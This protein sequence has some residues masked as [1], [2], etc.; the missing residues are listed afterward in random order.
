MCRVPLRRVSS[1]MPLR[2][3]LLIGLGL[4]LGLGQGLGI[5]CARPL[6]WWFP[7]G[8]DAAV[9]PPDASLCAVAP[10]FECTRREGGPCSRFI[11]VSPD[12]TPA[13][14]WHCPEGSEVLTETVQ[15]VDSC[16]PLYGEAS[17][18]VWLA[19]A[20]TPVER[21]DGRCM[22]ILSE[23]V[24]ETDERLS[25]PAVILPTSPAPG[26]C[27][28]GAEVLGGEEP[29]SV[30]DE[31]DLGDDDIASLG[32]GFRFGGRTWIY[33]RHWVW[34]ASQVFG[35]RLL[36]TRLAWYHD[37]SESVRFLDG[38]LWDAEVAFG[39]AAVVADGVPHVFGCH[40][41][42]VFLSTE[43]HVARLV[44]ADIG[45]PAAYEHYAGGDQWSDDIA[46]EVPIFE[47]GPHR[48]AVRYHPGV[49]RYVLLF[50]HGFGTQI[51]IRTAPEP[52]GPWTAPSVLADCDLPADDPD[53]FCAT[54]AMHLELMSDWHPDDLAVTYDIGTL[55]PDAEARRLADPAAYWPRLVRLPM[56]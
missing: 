5:G 29:F 10:G 3:V 36:G 23:G 45:D 54:P 14:A 38:F 12:C 26:N 18:F 2:G 55:A 9:A 4:G 56:H 30:A 11:T 43:C 51:E 7:S 22:W 47:S 15:P 52:Q 20:G 48:T 19:S 44:G 6:G 28:P 32:D 31:A 34:D 16:L 17:P 1:G 24:T 53:A 40:G 33:Y 13:G 21:G 25:H 50:A 49:G 8:E 27:L 37:E 39:D 35:V 46:E 41:P 42:P